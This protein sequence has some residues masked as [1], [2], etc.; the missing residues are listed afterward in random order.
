MFETHGIEKSPHS[1]ECCLVKI[2]YTIGLYYDVEIN[3]NRQ[4]VSALL[5]GNK[6]GVVL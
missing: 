4:S 2:D 5:Y 6:V 1:L 3:N